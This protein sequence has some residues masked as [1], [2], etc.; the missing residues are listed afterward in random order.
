MPS[1]LRVALDFLARPERHAYGTHREQRADLYV[2]RGSGPFPLVVVLHGGSWG[3]RYGKKVM[4][5]VC[6]DLQRRGL[7]CWNVEY[8]RLGGGQGGGWP[9][10]F[11]DVAAGIDH[12]ATLDDPRLDL[13]AGITGLGHSAG[14]QLAVWAA[15]RP[16]L[17]SDL[18]GADPRITFARV[19]ALAAPLDLARV[20]IARDLLG[21][22]L[23]EH[24]DR[25]AATDPVQLAPIGIPTLLVHGAADTT[26]PLARSRAYAAVARAGGDPVELVEPPGAGHRSH[27][28]PRT[29]VWKVA[30]DW[31]SAPER[32]V[33]A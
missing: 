28:D 19:A 11:A 10:T 22:T 23:A 1:T 31:L 25:Y 16:K 21:G 32:V 29:P 27:V 14:G 3:A 2:P 13:A 30:A 7:A 8:R 6:G 33:A 12:L 24:P 18:P 17:P 26:V 9:A 4:K 20:D 5:G 15:A